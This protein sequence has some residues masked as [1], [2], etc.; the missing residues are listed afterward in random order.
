MIEP[1]FVISPPKDTLKLL[2]SSPPFTTIESSED[3]LVQSI[4]KLIPL[5]VDET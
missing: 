5:D 3:K 1:G 2:N 4:V